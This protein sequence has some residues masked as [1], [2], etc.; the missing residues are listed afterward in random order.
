[1]S[2]EPLA[3]VSNMTK[4]TFDWLISFVHAKI[5]QRKNHDAQARPIRDALLSKA[6]LAGQFVEQR[7]QGR[8]A[9]MK[10]FGRGN[11]QNRSFC[12][13]GRCFRGYRE[14]GFSGNLC[15]YG[16]ITGHYIKFCRIRIANEGETK[17]GKP[18]NQDTSHQEEGNAHPQMFNQQ[19][20]DIFTDN[21][22]NPPWGGLTSCGGLVHSQRQS[23]F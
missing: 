12:G 21:G 11:Y 23:L 4:V 5:A 16:G 7:E 6:R 8:G 2:F 13:S 22:S 20:G 17:I 9:I 14:D 1:M 18:I 19:W 10:Y 3:M 15:H